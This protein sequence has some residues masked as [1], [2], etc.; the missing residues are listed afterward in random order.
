MLHRQE[1]SHAVY[2][3]GNRVDNNAKHRQ[4][5]GLTVYVVNNKRTDKKWEINSE[6]GQCVQVKFV[7]GNVDRTNIGNGEDDPTFKKNDFSMPPGKAVV[8]SY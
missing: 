5:H 6:L 1:D 7:I 3:E 4:G 2:V 8:L